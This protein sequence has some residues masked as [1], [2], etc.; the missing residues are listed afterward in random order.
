ML[1]PGSAVPSRYAPIR[2]LFVKIDLLSFRLTCRE[3]SGRELV[4]ERAGGGEQTVLPRDP[5]PGYTVSTHM[6]YSA[7]QFLNDQ[8]QA[9]AGARDAFNDAC[10]SAE[11]AVGGGAA[12]SAFGEFFT[13]WFS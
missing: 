12:A 3:V 6:L 10:Y 9:L 4:P 8:A 7:A 11:G 5:G 13:A 2:V 1:T